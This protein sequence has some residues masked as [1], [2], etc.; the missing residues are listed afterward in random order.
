MRWFD[1]GQSAMMAALEHGPHY[2]PQHL[3]AG[4]PE[5]VLIGMKVHANTISH[6]RLVA[7]EDTYPRTRTVLG[8]ERFNAECRRFLACPGVAARPL[9]QIGAGFAEFLADH[10]PCRKGADLARFEWHWLTAYH[11]ADAAPLMLGALTGLSPETLMDQ[12][13]ACH[14]AAF[15]GDFGRFVH[16]YLDTEIAC[17]A[18]AEAILITRPDAAVLVSPASA[19][20]GEILALAKKPVTIGNLLAVLAEPTD[21]GAAPVDETMQALIALINAGA[22]TAA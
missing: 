19:L 16:D 15:A 20:M 11:A 7:L 5:R 6:A 4:P 14:P 8:A 3:F 2:L 1:G 13:L 22:I 18:G 17:L 12:K 10:L 9:T 21:N